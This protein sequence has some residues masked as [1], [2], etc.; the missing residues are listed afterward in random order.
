MFGSCCLRQASKRFRPP[1]GGR[2]TF[3]LLAQRESSQRETAPRWRALQ[4][5]CLAGARAGYGVFRRDS[6]PGEKLAGIHAGHP[7]GFPSPTR[8]AI[9]AP[10]RAARSQRAEATAKAKA[11]SCGALASASGAHDARL[12]LWGPWAAVRRGRSGRTAGIARDGDAF[13]R[14]QEPARKAR[15]R[16]T[17]LPGR[18]PGK[19]QPGWPLFWLL[20]SG[21]AEKSDS[22]AGGRSKPL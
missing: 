11:G 19:R 10:G 6:C 7:A 15:P 16:L 8:R 17:D 4:A 5:S 12:L 1:V 18:T 22:G 14:G 3:S 9:G 20:F 13:S 21:H 2:A